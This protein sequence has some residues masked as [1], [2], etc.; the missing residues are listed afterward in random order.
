MKRLAF[1]LLLAGFALGLFGGKLWLVAAAGF[2]LPNMDAWDAEADHLLRPFVEGRPILPEIFR[3]QNEHR[4]VTTKLHA[5]GL[6]LANDHQWSVLLELV[7]NAV[8]HTCCAVA[9]LLLAR[10][11]LCGPWLLAFAALL[12]L[13]FASPFAWENTLNGF[14][15]QFYYLLLF[16]LLQLWLTLGEP[17][18]AGFTPRW[19]VGHT[20]GALA[21]VSMAS[22]FFASLIILGL[23]GERLLRARRLAPQPLV[24]AL[25]ALALVIAGILLK[26]PFPG[27]D[28]LRV[29]SLGAFAVATLQLLAWPSPGLLPWLL[30]PVCWFLFREARH[31]RTA[32]TTDPVLRALLAWSL[33]QCLALA[34]AR[35]GGDQ[36]LSSRYLDLVALN[37]AL[38][39]V[40]LVNA[41]TGRR[42][43]VLA[44]TWLVAA[45][46]LLVHVGDV[47]WRG[48]IAPDL[49]L[50]A[51]QQ[52]HTRDYVR[53]LDPRHILDH[54]WPEIPYIS[55]PGLIERL[56]SPALRAVLPPGIR[57]PVSLAPAANSVS[58]SLPPSLPATDAPLALSTFAPATAHASPVVWRSADQTANSPSLL[59]FRLAGDLGRVDARLTLTL[60]SADSS[61]PIA[62]ETAPGLRW[63]TMN[64]PRPSAPWHLEASDADPAAWFAVTEPV[65]IGRLAWI[66]EKLIKSSRSFVLAGA[67]LLVAGGAVLLFRSSR[68]A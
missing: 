62:P 57:R 43:V 24:T 41:C 26:N 36:V 52:A 33:L 11:W 20:C 67:L 1:C 39:F 8:V 32:S 66:A 64:L 17:A 2:D 68:P 40:L 61:Q 42:R 28:V 7:A 44:G 31:W 63:K 45:A 48:A 55:E 10:R 35:G 27:H 65:E 18:S 25:V 22:G 21:V 30:A 3:P 54:P 15:V 34:Y 16:S 50:H 56:A 53:T 58:V 12:L 19:F 49:A 23:A 38:A 5:L 13:L 46:A 4:L 29:H 59:R 60:K 14:Q 37:L 51:R 9:L 47:Q 6:F